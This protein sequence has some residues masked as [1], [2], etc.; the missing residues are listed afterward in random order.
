MWPIDR[1]DLSN[2]RASQ[3]KC[4]G[5]DNISKFKSAGLLIRAPQSAYLP[6]SGNGDWDVKFYS[7][8]AILGVYRSGNSHSDRPGTLLESRKVGSEAPEQKIQGLGLYTERPEDDNLDLVRRSTRSETPLRIVRALTAWM[9]SPGRL[10]DSGEKCCKCRETSSTKATGSRPPQDDTQK[11][12][13][14]PITRDI[15]LWEGSAILAGSIRTKN[16]LDSDV[17]LR[18]YIGYCLAFGLFSLRKRGGGCAA[19]I[20]TRPLRGF[21]LVRTKSSI[22]SAYGGLAGPAFFLRKK[23]NTKTSS[24]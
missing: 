15:D 11:P 8:V 24:L 6:Y 1:S 18:P 23:F 21:C 7:R 4:P 14:G 5:R 9:P 17:T 3:V 13:I 12:R 10:L 20:P 22:S 19:T 16:H 2:K